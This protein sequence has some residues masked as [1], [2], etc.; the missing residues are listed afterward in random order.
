[1]DGRVQEP[2]IKFLK[3]KYKVDFVDMITEAR[4]MDRILAER[5][6]KFWKK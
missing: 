6:K 5:D 4:G 2:V 1:M 3:E